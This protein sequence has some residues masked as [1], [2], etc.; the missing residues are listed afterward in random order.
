[1]GVVNQLTSVSKNGGV[2]KYGGTPSHPKLD[3]FSIETQVFGIP[4]F[5]KFPYTKYDE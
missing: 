2:K 1:M 3:D 4:H 5:K